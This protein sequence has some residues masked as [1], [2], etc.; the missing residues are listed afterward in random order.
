M[1]ITWYDMLIYRLFYWRW[2]RIMAERPDLRRL[3]REWLN[4]YELL[5]VFK[6]QEDS[7]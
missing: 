7:K 6:E 3:F 4:R 2:N 1:K 5:E